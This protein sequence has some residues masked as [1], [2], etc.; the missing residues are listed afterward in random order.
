VVNETFAR[1]F[2]PG[3]NPLLKTFGIADALP[4]AMR[5]TVVGVVRNFQLAREKP[6]RPAIFSSYR[7]TYLDDVG[8]L[9]RPT[10]APIEALAT[11]SRVIREFDPA[12]SSANVQT[13]NQALDEVIGPR[14]RVMALLIGFAAVSLALGL[15]G[16]YGVTTY[17]AS[18]RRHEI[19]IR[20]ALGATP[21]TVRSLLV[22]RSMVPVLAGVVIGAPCSI[23]LGHLLAHQMFGVQSLDPV[24]CCC[25]IGLMFLAAAPACFIPAFRASRIDPMIALRYE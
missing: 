11:V 17:S 1:C 18:Q 13:M 15:V 6:D 23:L 22:A 10:G 20:L 8:M 9:V 2:W 16:I 12:Q 4:N 21:G 3:K 19:G 25:G 14:N 5:Y 24:A 7:A